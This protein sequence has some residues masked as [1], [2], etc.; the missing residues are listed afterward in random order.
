MGSCLTEYRYA[1]HLFMGQKRGVHGI[2][3]ARLYVKWG[4]DHLDIF[5]VNR[6]YAILNG[7]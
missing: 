2:I 7:A 1:E 6:R 4:A 5:T 3:Q